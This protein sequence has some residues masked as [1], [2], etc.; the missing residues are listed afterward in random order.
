[1]LHHFEWR[2]ICINYLEFISTGSSMLSHL[3]INSITYYISL[4]ICIYNLLYDIVILYFELSNTTL[5]LK[6]FYL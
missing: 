6:L 5:L 4:M 3:F 2:T 1:M